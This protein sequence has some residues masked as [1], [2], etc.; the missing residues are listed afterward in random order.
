MDEALKHKFLKDFKG[1]ESEPISCM[2]LM[3]KKA[4]YLCH[5]MKIKKIQYR[6]I[7]EQFMNLYDNLNQEIQ[8][9]LNNSA[10][11]FNVKVNQT[12]NKL[13]RM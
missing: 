13:V 4:K 10:T 11:V 6:N 7:E 9:Y 12:L 8:N 2:K 5:I 1:T 3:I